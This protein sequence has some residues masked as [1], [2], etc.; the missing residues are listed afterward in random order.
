MNMDTQHKAL[1]MLHDFREEHVVKQEKQ[2]KNEKMKSKVRKHHNSKSDEPDLQESAV[3]KKI[4]AYQRKLLNQQSAVVSLLSLQNYFARNFYNMR[5][6]AL[7]VAFAINFILLFYKVTG[8]W[9][10]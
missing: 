2:V 10:W 3:L 7:F 1:S 8:N 4:L 5:M 9:V 6:L